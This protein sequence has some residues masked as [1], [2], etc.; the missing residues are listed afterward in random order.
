MLDRPFTRMEFKRAQSL[1][2]S[3]NETV[4]DCGFRLF[5]FSS[6]LLCGDPV[7]ET[8]RSG[9]YHPGLRDNLLMPDD[10]LSRSYLPSIPLGRAGHEQSR[11]SRRTGEPEGAQPRHYDF[12]AT[13]PQLPR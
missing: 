10:H 12:A 6:E 13:F 2:S 8:K 11:A 3:F 9:T 5:A 1:R 4:L 7:W